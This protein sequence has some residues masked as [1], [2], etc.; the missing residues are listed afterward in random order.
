MGKRTSYDPYDHFMLRAPLFPIGLLSAIPELPEELFT[1]L[2]SMWRDPLVREGLMLGSFEFSQRI[3]QEFNSGKPTPPDNGLLH[4][5]LRYLCR[6]SSRCTPFG[7]FAGFCTGEIGQFT[8]MVLGEQENHFLHARPD[9]EYLM[10]IARLL[11]V[12]PSIRESLLFTANTSLYKV[13]SRWHYVEIKIPPGNHKKSYDIV[14]IDDGSVIEDLLE[15]CV[16]GRTTDEIRIYLNGGGW[17]ENEVAEFVESLVDSQVIVS[18]IE[19]VVCGPEYIE[20]LTSSFRPEC[21]DHPI[22]RSLDEIREV[23]DQIDHPLAVLKSLPSL[24]K[25]LAGIPVSVNRNHLIQ[26]DMNLCHSSM[27]IDMSISNQILLGLRILKSISM[28]STPELLNG[29]SEAFTKRYGDRKVQLVKALDPETGIGLEGAVEGYWTDPVAWIDDLNWGPAFNKSSVESNPGNHWLQ[30]KI[31]EIIRE[32]KLYLTLESSDLQSI[33]I[34]EGSWPNQMTAL[35]ELFE[36]ESDQELNIHFLH[37]SAGNPS[38]LLGRFGFADPDSTRNWISQLIADEIALSPD[39]VFAE[40][41][42]LPEDRTGNVLQRPSFLNFEIPYLANSAKSREFQIPVTDLMISVDGK[43]I[44]LTSASSG[45]KIR[46][47]MTN[48]YNHQLGNLAIYKFLY[49]V[50]FQ[51]PTSSFRPHWGDIIS[52]ASFIPGV[53]FKNMILTAPIWFIHCDEIA[54]WFHPEKNEV[55]LIDLLAWREA[56]QMPEEMLWIS[57][58]QELFF[59]WRN[60]NLLLALWDSIRNHDIVR[61]RPFYLSQG[62]PVKGPDGVYANQMVLCYRKS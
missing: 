34:H 53:R 46:P 26:V 61:V 59:N 28:T 22:V 16:D 2:K 18:G 23:F 8:S 14:T 56:K 7:T 5:L 55:D 29:F 54:K 37:G 20:M 33:G 19:P 57:S 35:V 32:G 13:G 58:D 17:P 25:I 24:E 30:G 45:K 52:Q 39:E 27:T 3:D 51:E 11:Q 44:I 42:H 47:R 50:Q 49:R 41:I 1:W 10:G 15:Y 12:D 31:F 21:R 60:P 40:V 36:T 9:M 48:A 4:S 38:F 43:K 62:T 6:F